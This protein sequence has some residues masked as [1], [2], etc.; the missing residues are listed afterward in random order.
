MERDSVS[1]MTAR[2]VVVFA[3]RVS[4]RRRLHLPVLY[5]ARQ[6]T[7]TASRPLIWTA[8]GESDR[9]MRESDFV[10]SRIKYIPVRSHA[11]GPVK[12]VCVNAIWC[13]INANSGPESPTQSNQRNRRNRASKMRGR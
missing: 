4:E 10:S 6:V 3:E 1:Q 12:L 7:N 2:N 9:L 11:P 13:L 5:W 8:T